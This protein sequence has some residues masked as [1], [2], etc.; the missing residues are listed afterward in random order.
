MC[1][2]MQNIDTAGEKVKKQEQEQEQEQELELE[3][4]E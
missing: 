3:G 2:R 1:L 4:K